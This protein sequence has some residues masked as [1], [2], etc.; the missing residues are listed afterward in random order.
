ML[1]SKTMEKTALSEVTKH[2][3]LPNCRYLL[4]E[5]TWVVQA[6]WRGSCSA[7]AADWGSG[8]ARKAAAAGGFWHK[9]S[10]GGE[11]A[12]Y[13][14]SGLVGCTDG[15]STFLSK[16]QHNNNTANEFLNYIA[17]P[18]TNLFSLHLDEF[19]MFCYLF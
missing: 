2:L 19:I 3:F 6:G 4:Q 7:A 16:K 12:L 8:A 15:T 14:P 13:L 9:M 18:V 1:D 5:H 10:P 11:E 17:A